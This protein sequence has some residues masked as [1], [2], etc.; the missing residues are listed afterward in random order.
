MNYKKKAV[1]LNEQSDSSKKRILPKQLSSLS[2]LQ[3]EAL[4]KFLKK[5]FNTTNVI[6]PTDLFDLA[7]FSALTQKNIASIFDVS[8][9]A[10]HKWIGNGCPRNDDKT[11]NL[12]NVI[13][14]HVLRVE[15][16]HESGDTVD[17]EKKKAEIERINAQIAKMKNELVPRVE[18][19]TILASMAG[20]LK[21]FLE[22]S[23]PM[24]DHLFVGLSL[25]EAR[26]RRRSEEKQMMDAF[27]G[28][29]QVYADNS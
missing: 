6:T 29:M 26:T 8:V 10:V 25:D 14:W 13:D 23:R 22:Y 16:K 5:I 18:M 7:D 11:Y 21:A 20:S 15:K 19:E 24:N 27:T 28:E 9:Q 1:K 3:R 2:Q 4:N 17:V 12:K